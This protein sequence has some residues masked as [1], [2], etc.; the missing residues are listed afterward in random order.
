LHDVNYYT[1]HRYLEPRDLT[2]A[3]T[4]E[5]Y[6][7]VV[8]TAVLSTEHE[9]NGRDGEHWQ[10]YVDT[11][12]G[13]RYQVDVNIQSSDGAATEMYVGAENLD[14]TG[15]SPDEPYGSPQYGVF[16]ASLSYAAIGLADAM[17]EPVDSLRIR[18]QL[19]AALGQSVFVAVYGFVFDDGGPR[20]KGIH[21]THLNVKHT[22]EDG[23]L[24]IYGKDAKGQPQRT[25]FFFK[26]AEDHIAAS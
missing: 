13:V 21:E 2:P 16:P 17:F 1:E 22:D 9:I 20:G 11:G 23:A 7:A 4:P 8:G 24:A 25:W 18:Q 14:P 26:F 15:V 6:A 10:F 12:N 3:R 19:E 5:R